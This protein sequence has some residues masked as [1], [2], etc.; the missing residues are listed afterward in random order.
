MYAS[1]PGPASHEALRRPHCSLRSGMDRPAN[2]QS[3]ISVTG[4]IGVIN[5]TVLPASISFGLP[6]GEVAERSKA[7]LC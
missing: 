7:A 2:H 6:F 4:A 3:P 5:L 1:N